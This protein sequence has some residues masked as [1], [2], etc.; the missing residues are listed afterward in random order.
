MELINKIYNKKRR[1][2]KRFL[3]NKI[4]LNCKTEED[5]KDLFSN[6]K[7]LSEKRKNDFINYWNKYKE[8]TCY[9]CCNSYYLFDSIEYFQEY[10]QKKIKEWK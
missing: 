3:K 10:E 2:L 7:D 4:I 5:A 9:E 1:L 8:N 6:I